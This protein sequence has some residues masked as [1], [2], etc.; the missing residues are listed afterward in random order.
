[1]TDDTLFTGSH[2]CTMLAQDIEQPYIIQVGAAGPQRH[3]E[4]ILNIATH[5]SLPYTRR[6]HST[7]DCR[8]SGIAERQ[9]TDS[10]TDGALNRF[11]G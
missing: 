2:F 3:V 6:G 10:G 5:T 4:V 9:H 11:K 1:M 7:D 8:P